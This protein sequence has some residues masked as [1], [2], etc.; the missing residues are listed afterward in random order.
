MCVLIGLCLKD[1]LLFEQT[2]ACTIR[3]IDKPIMKPS[4]KDERSCIQEETPAKACV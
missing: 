4:I 2:I 3:F 1:Y